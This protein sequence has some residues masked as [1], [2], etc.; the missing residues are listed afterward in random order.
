M[1]TEPPHIT[2]YDSTVLE[3]GMI[4]TIEPG[5]VTDYGV[6]QAEE[7][8]LVTTKGYEILSTACTE[9]ASIKSK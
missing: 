4:I 6:F 7:N 2:N 3:P 9:L 8:V 1:L 5:F